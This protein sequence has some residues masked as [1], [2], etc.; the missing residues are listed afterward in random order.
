M[1]G[2]RRPPNILHLQG[3]GRPWICVCVCLVFAIPLHAARRAMAAASCCF[4]GQRAHFPAFKHIARILP[5]TIQK[6]YWGALISFRPPPNKGKEKAHQKQN[7]QREKRK[8]DPPTSLSRLHG[9]LSQ[10]SFLPR[11]DLRLAHILPLGDRGLVLGCLRD[12]GPLLPA[13]AGRGSPPLRELADLLL[14]CTGIGP[15][16]MRALAVGTLGSLI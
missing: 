9:S 7:K 14:G 16:P 11:F 3:S 1:F 15:R 13:R 8:Q 4:D 10:S 5:P 6:S 12:R 2:R